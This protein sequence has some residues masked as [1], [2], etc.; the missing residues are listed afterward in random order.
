MVMLVAGPVAGQT[1]AELLAQ[2][3]ALQAQ[4]LALQGAQPAPAPAFVFTRDLFVGVS[5]DDVRALQNYLVGAGFFR[6][7]PTGFFGPV[8]RAAVAAWQAANGVSP[9]AGFFGAR[10]RA[11]YNQL[12][13]AV[14]TPPT[15]PVAPLQGA[16]GLFR[17]VSLMTDVS[18]AILR[19]AQTDRRII[20]MEFE[21]AGSDLR[22]A[23]VD[24][25]FA[26]GLPVSGTPSTRPWRYFDRVSLFRGATL[27]AS[28]A[29]SDSADWSDEGIIPTFGAAGSRV[30]RMSFTGLNEIVRQNDRTQLYIAVTMRSTI[31]T[32][33]AGARW[34]VRIPVNG[35]RA[36]DAAGINQFAPVS[37]LDDSASF[38]TAVAGTG[39][40]GADAVLN[41][42]RI[43]E[44]HAVNDTNDVEVANFTLR[45]RDGDIRVTA[46]TV[47]MTEA[48]AGTAFLADGVR[49]FRLL[50]NGVLV[51]T[52]T[53]PA[54]GTAVT[55]ADLN[56]IVS[57]GATDSFVL[58][59]DMRDTESAVFVNANTLRVTGV[60][61]TAEDP[62]TGRGVSLTG[63]VSGGT[64]AFFDAG[65]RPT[66]VSRSATRTLI[67]D[68]AGEFDQ[69][70][71]VIRFNVTAFGD[72]MWIPR[73]VLIQ[74]G[75]LTPG[76]GTSG[77]QADIMNAALGEPPAA[78]QTLAT[79]ALTTNAHIGTSAFQIL[80]DQ[81]REFTLTVT[82]T[83]SATD[84]WVLLALESLGFSPGAGG[85]KATPTTI[86]T[87][88]LDGNPDWRTDA[89]FLNVFP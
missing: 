24:V 5:G 76:A 83:A 79:S 17:N 53:A 30:Y 45:A 42:D 87:A 85:D 64:L 80:Q 35:V 55:I 27:V 82:A 46:M 51:R 63:A 66:L 23:R 3:Q 84:A 52:V 74:D 11:M 12:V 65:I 29:A 43:V 13:A 68:A 78:V 54:T 77:T 60:T 4:L 32:A 33:D 49:R 88:G 9:A 70:T 58:R 15:P 67:A 31:D 38:A 14:V 39:T 40:L 89:I 16:E 75:N 28:R 50:R 37:V 69:G 8:T 41:R 56:F 19:E 34:L 21:A 18:G 44:V 61:V 1:I 22:V 25:L 81:T 7:T 20:G 57:A 47:P 36:V 48:F 71:Y 73:G 62:V 86:L 2:I 10:S 59:A 26:A 6:A 72:Q